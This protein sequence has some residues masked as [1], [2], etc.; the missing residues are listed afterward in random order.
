MIVF[1]RVKWPSAEKA[2]VNTPDDWPWYHWILGVFRTRALPLV[3]VL[4]SCAGT[5]EQTTSPPTFTI[6]QTE[7]TS[8]PIATTSLSPSTSIEPTTT[9]NAG[10]VAA[11]FLVPFRIPTADL[12]PRFSLGDGYLE[13]S[14]GTGR[15]LM[16][17]TAGWDTAAEWVEN[18]TTD[19]RLIASEPQAMEIGGLASTVLEVRLNGLEFPPFT[20]SDTDPGTPNVGWFVEEGHLNRF[21]ITE[22][23]GEAVA[24]VADA[25][26]DEAAEFFVEARL[27]WPTS[28]GWPTA[29]V[30][31]A[32]G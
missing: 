1:R 29:D 20:Y 4:V 26:E 32:T 16:F 11:D 12:I 7:T 25:P 15:I 14:A 9:T 31:R 13:F 23:S 17:T 21:F 2:L 19:S 27:C 6:S 22:L 28:N 24:I 18:L 3:A 5:A 30:G 10:V 8:A